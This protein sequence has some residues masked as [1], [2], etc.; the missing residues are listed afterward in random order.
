MAD[1]LDDVGN[2]VTA[3]AGSKLSLSDPSKTT[4]LAGIRVFDIGQGDCIGLLDQRGEVFCYVDYGGLGDHPDLGSKATNPT[5]ARMSVHYGTGL[6]TIILTHWDKDHYYSAKKY[7]TDAQK[8][9]WL[10]PRQMASPQAVRFA[11]KLTNALCWPEARKKTA[12]QFSVGTDHYIEIQKCELFVANATKE[13]RNTTGLAITLLRYQD[14]QL[15]TY[16]LLPGDCHFDGIPTLPKGVPIRT[17]IAY[18]HGSHTDWNAHTKPTI[19]KTLVSPRSMAYSYGEN[20]T[21]GHPQHSNYQTE[22][23]P[24]ATRTPHLRKASR[25]YEDFLW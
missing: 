9:Q 22:W 25:P 18:H 2:A 8:C 19:A 5:S 15:K 17:L 11:A 24:F 7:N 1:P 16:M 6:T 23:D 3:V 20:N 12:V 10:V 21:Y 4:A 13:D 14:G